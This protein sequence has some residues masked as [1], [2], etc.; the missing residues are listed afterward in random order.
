MLDAVLLL[1]DI[2]TVRKEKSLSSP[3]R[4]RRRKSCPNSIR[5]QPRP[6]H[7]LSKPG[8][9]KL[10]EADRR[11]LLEMYADLLGREPVPLEPTVPRARVSL[12]TQTELTQ[13][14]AIFALETIAGLN[15]LAFELVEADKVRII[16]T[17]QARK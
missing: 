17:A 10:Q 16:P 7:K 9:I 6:N 12:R 4:L 8:L 14:E 1:G 3:S 2:A 11:Q 15:H 5:R 13:S